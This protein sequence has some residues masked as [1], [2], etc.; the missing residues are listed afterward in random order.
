MKAKK[1]TN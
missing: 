1:N